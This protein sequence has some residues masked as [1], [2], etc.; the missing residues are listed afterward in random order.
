ME[1]FKMTI[2][3]GESLT[4][5]FSMRTRW[6]YARISG[7]AGG[8]TLRLSL[9]NGTSQQISNTIY[10][11]ISG[12]Y[13]VTLSAAQTDAKSIA[14]TGTHTNGNYV[15][16]LIVLYTH[17]LKETRDKVFSNGDKADT[18]I[19]NTTNIETKVDTA[20]TNINTIDGKVDVIDTN[21]DTLLV[22]AS[23]IETK[24]DIIDNNVDTSLVN[25]STIDGKVD[26][27]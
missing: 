23:D 14:L 3:R 21:V 4:V 27:V 2:Q 19:T 11:R 1:D 20:N 5:Y 22:N 15:I 25:L 26:V 7:E 13:S 17:E 12:V 6:D 18:L 9:D 16:D 10:E 8:I 24:V